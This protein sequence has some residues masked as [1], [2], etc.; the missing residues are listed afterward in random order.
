MKA[1]TLN[2]VPKRG[3]TLP[4]TMAALL[5]L[6]L[7]TMALYEMLGAERRASG[8]H[9]RKAQAELSAQSGL[10]YAL[11]R[12]EQQSAPWRT[13]SLRHTGVDPA[14]SFEISA[15]QDGPFS[16]VSVRNLGRDSGVAKLE[17]HGGFRPRNM[18]AIILLNPSATLALVG[19]AKIHGSIA[20]KT[21][22]VEY[23]T[24]YM[25]PA[26]KD[27]SFNGP[28][29]GADWKFWDS[30][31]FHADVSRHIFDDLPGED[32]CTFDAKDTL[33][34]DVE[35][36][37]VTLRGDAFCSKC[38]ISAGRVF[39]KERAVLDK[40]DVKAKFISLSGTGQVSGTFFAQ[41]TL[42]ADLDS[43]QKNAIWL[44]VQGRKTGSNAYSGS[45][46]INRLNAE[47]AT[48]MFFGDNWDASLPG[49]SAYISS[50][51]KISGRIIIHGT[52][53]MHGTLYGALV[54]WDFS[55]DESGTRWNGFLK[56]AS[57]TE[58]STQAELIPDAIR[59][60]GRAGA[61]AL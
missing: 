27:A 43:V 52:L 4:L 46:E 14:V 6:S 26:G 15:Q 40:A 19:N 22:N 34:Q 33:P 12:M 60:G 32:F 37:T 45:L 20:I 7:L 55:F 3:M 61:E 42:S 2:S 48:L 28:V 56:D 18:P 50:Q 9:L 58:D 11:F 24:N 44:C 10:E 23:S 30:I 39:I 38:T 35:C 5:I 17:M 54:A 16:K 53:D 13:E 21:G 49:I 47:R 31:S 57:I 51:S 59:L 8:R 41:D 29:L 1:T 25:Q 36:G